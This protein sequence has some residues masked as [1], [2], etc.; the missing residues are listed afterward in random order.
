MARGTRFPNGL[1]DVTLSGATLTN[2]LIDE[3]RINERVDTRTAN[4]TA[5][6]GDSVIDPDSSTVQVTSANANNI[7]T[8]P[9]PVVGKRLTLIVGANGYE[10]RSN[11][12]ATVG[13]GGGVGANAESA[14]PANSLAVV[15]CI[16]ATNWVGYTITAATL[17]AVEAAA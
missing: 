5:G 16:S 13:I 6:A 3:A 11:A 12:P 10:L 14:I 15:V 8:L 4:A 9:A 17:A 2:P 1:K 7:I